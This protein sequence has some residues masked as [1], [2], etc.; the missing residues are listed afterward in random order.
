MGVLNIRYTSDKSI[1]LVTFNSICRVFSCK[2]IFDAISHQPFDILIKKCASTQL[3][4][5]SHE[6]CKC[7]AAASAISNNS[8]RAKR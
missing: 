8:S 2:M 6:I 7:A 1:M 3:N 5:L 4:D